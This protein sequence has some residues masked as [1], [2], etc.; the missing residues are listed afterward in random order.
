MRVH[1][2]WM[3]RRDL[4]E[5]LEI[6][7]KRFEFPWT[8]DDFIRTMCQR[9]V[10]GMVAEHDEEIVG[11]F[12]YALLRREIELLNFAVHP[13]YDR[14]GVGRQMVER[15]KAKLSHERRTRVCVNVG[16]CNTA[17]H[18]FF[19]RMEFRA[20]SVVHKPYKDVYMDAYR[21]V[22]DLAPLGVTPVNR[23]SGFLTA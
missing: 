3:I 4:P 6:E 16:E 18:L 13:R 22:Y 19:R 23:I 7:R 2:R 9:N 5:I 15:L 14:E 10:I 8:E 20:V 1:I 11:Y 21:F 17:A 12:L